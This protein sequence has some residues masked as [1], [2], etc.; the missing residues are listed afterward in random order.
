[1]EL[2]REARKPGFRD[3][4]VCVFPGAERQLAE[5]ATTTLTRKQRRYFRAQSRAPRIGPCARHYCCRCRWRMRRS[6]LR[7]NVHVRIQTNGVPR[8]LH[9]TSSGCEPHPTRGRLVCAANEHSHPRQLAV[10]PTSPVNQNHKFLDNTER[11]LY[12]LDGA[13]LYV[14][15]NRVHV[16]RG[17]FQRTWGI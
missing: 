1:M 12:F 2:S 17:R 7:L 11:G 13:C 10:C 8:R 14:E 15:T 3:M 16:A 6:S 9:R 4:C 5:G